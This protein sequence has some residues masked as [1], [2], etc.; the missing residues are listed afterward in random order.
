M[1]SFQATSDPGE[2]LTQISEH[3]VFNG[4]DPANDDPRGGL[5]DVDGDGREPAETSVPSSKP[6]SSEFGLRESV[7]PGSRHQT[8]VPPESHTSIDEVLADEDPVGPGEAS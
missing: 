2:V 5:A 6:S 4:G 8:G 1:R 7:I 3:D